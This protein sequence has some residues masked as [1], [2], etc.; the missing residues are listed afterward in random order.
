MKKKAIHTAASYDEF[1]NFVACAEQKPLGRGEMESLK[2]TKGSWKQQLTR[3]ELNK[4]KVRW[5]GEGGTSEASCSGGV[6]LF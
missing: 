1:K 3:H 5:G 2:E 4:K 6:E